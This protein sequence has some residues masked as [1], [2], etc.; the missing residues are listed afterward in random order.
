[1]PLL[2]LGPRSPNERSQAD[3]EQGLA[4]PSRDA[5]ESAHHQQQY[6]AGLLFVLDLTSE[7]RQNQQTYFQEANC[8]LKMVSSHPANFPLHFQYKTISNLLTMPPKKHSPADFLPVSV[9]LMERRIYL[10]RGH[11]VMLDTH[12]AELY[13]VATKVFNQAVKRNLDRFPEDFMF[14][15]NAE[16]ADSLRSQFVTASKRNIRFRPYAFTEHGVLML[17][18]VLNSDRAIQVNI[19]IMRVFIKLR[20]ALS[21]HSDLNR[22][23]EDL[24]KMQKRQGASITEI[25]LAVE[26]LIKAHRQLPPAIGYHTK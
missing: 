5:L 6:G 1:V 7:C 14:Q 13:Q 4:G 26:K 18:S 19:M 11:K 22:K 25:I 23:M 12:L 20:E 8:N 24:E 17:S 9:E 3:D 15:L 10:I 21:T 16:E 2:L